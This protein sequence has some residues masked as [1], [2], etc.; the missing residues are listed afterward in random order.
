MRS[1]PAVLRGH[2]RRVGRRQR[3]VEAA[4]GRQCSQRH[5]REAAGSGA[6]RGRL[7][8][9]G[10]RGAHGARAH[11]LETRAQSRRPLARI[12]ASNDRI[13]RRITGIMPVVQ[14]LALKSS[15]DFFA[16]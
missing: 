15:Q 11:R 2:R 13:A 10:G 4:V 9:V 7:G 6:G 3:V 14:I 16:L 12:S 1:R 5:Q 8:G